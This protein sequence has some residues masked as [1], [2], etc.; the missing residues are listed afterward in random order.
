MANALTTDNFSSIYP[1]A[2]MNNKSA[3]NAMAWSP[4]NTNYISDVNDKA[5]PVKGVLVTVAG[6]LNLVFMNQGVSE[7]VVIPV[8]A[9]VVYPFAVK[10]IRSTSTTATGIVVFW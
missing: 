10:M 9:N 5:L 7:A 4:S 3:F 6:N 8:A 1:N 2:N